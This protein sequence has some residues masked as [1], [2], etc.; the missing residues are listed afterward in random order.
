MNKKYNSH[1]FGLF[2]IAAIFITGCNAPKN[3]LLKFNNAFKTGCMNNFCLEDSVKI[4]RS[5]ISKSKNPK[6]ED[7]LWSMQL[8]SIERLKQNHQQSNEYFDKSE[9]M[10][11]FFDYQNTTVD[12]AA[13][14]AV[15][16][17]IIPYTGREY[18]G[19]MINTYK[20]LN[21][22]ALGENDLARVEF[23][24]ALDRQRRAR[25]KF[26]KEI[27]KLQNELD[28]E[29][30]KK[31]SQVKKNVEN[32]EIEQIIAE[33]YPGIYNFQAYPDFVNPFATY[34][35]G[36]FFNLDG[37]YSKAAPLFKEAY[38]M[39]GDN[40]Y[41]AQD[42]AITDQILDSR[43]RLTDTVWV[44]F[45][46]GMGPVKDEFR[47]DIPL[48]V[49][50]KKI[51]YIGIALPRLEFRE[52][53]YPGLLIKTADGN[54]STKQV[55]DMDRV[56]QTEFEKDFKAT[57]TRAIISTTSKAV[58]QYAL[59]KKDD[60]KATLASFLVA[61][62]TFAT[63]AADVRIWSTLP[64]DFQVARFAIPADRK[65]TIEPQGGQSF[66]IEIPACNNAL[67]YVRIPFRSAKPVYDIITY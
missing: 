46:N 18:D 31:D 53:A 44:I 22:M 35:A 37:D 1:I 50:T 49:D 11:N 8:G 41:L 45:E 4:A 21:F 43:K 67:V 61:A 10:L 15:N 52:Q 12:S 57:L 47:I 13:A 29:Q 20:A 27:A 59:E 51:K 14:I 66:Q 26:A 40:E 54:Y 63:T 7:L 19:I 39:V 3:D 36:V 33:Q 24:R 9:E 23:N 2:L 58:A 48:F 17:N 6:A 30:E 62:Y 32:P 34:I 25:E 65:I 60:S 16:E 55:A 64:K 42:L 38:G 28:K 5:K 56:I